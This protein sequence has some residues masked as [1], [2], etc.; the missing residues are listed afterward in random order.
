MP[1][2]LILIAIAFAAVSGFPGL[3]FK[4][5]SGTGQVIAFVLMGIGS[6]TGLAG[7]G[8]GLFSIASASFAFP[9]PAVENTIIGL[10]PLSAFFL[11]PVFLTGGLGSLYGLGYWKQK[12]HPH[13]AQRLQFF[14]GFLVSGIGLLIIGRHALSFLLGWEIMALS[15]F[16]LVSTEDENK[17][18]RKSA[19]VY[20][21]STH[22]STLVLFGFFALWKWTTGSFSL[23]PIAEGAVHPVLLNI[24][25]FLALFGFGLKAGMMPLHFWLPGAHASAP[26]HVSAMLS[27][28]MLKIGIYGLVRI[29]LLLPAPPVIWGGSIL[30]FGLVSG[31]FGVIFALSQHDVKRLL[32]YH[33][34]ENIGIILMGL[35]L[36][37]L[38]R[39]F[40]K[41][42]WV[43][44]G[45]AGCLL[46]VWNHSLFKTLLFYG[47]GSVI[48]QTG[49][50][51]IDML[52]GL[53]KSM[54]WTA[55]FFLIG[56]IA[57]S[58]IPPLN[59]FISEFI[60]FIGLIR[61]VTI[62]GRQTIGLAFSA[63]I[64]AMI[65]ALASACFI[66]VY[67]A[68][69]LGSPRTHA[70]L[71]VHE[72]PAAMIIPMAILALICTTI[73]TV[74]G[75]VVPI[76]ESVTGQMV[77]SQLIPLQTI[78]WIAGGFFAGVLFIALG[79]LIKNRKRKRS[80]TWDCGYAEPTSRMQ[81][82]A[83]SFGHSLTSMFGWVL[84]PQE[85]KPKLKEIY[86]APASLES[87]VD[88]VVLD[89]ALAP[90]F[91]KVKKIFAWFNKFQR[92]QTQNYLLYIL[93]TVLLFLFALIPF[94]EWILP[95]LKH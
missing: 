42:E 44:L 3:F 33:S 32:A 55:L 84:R 90:V 47:A 50:R 7:A 64:L 1:L 15:A 69:F 66:K 36:A 76:L 60:I 79:V 22:V 8:L 2:T 12:D 38:G 39:S 18:T 86:P 31:L 67:T 34:V 41:P 73:G 59:G 62:D 87:H 71:Y 70:S 93:I 80:V 72:A 43:A 35:G 94:E 48:R 68:V 92:G 49:R 82:T 5:T 28:V 74:P 81:Y 10:D 78:S 95:L 45:M 58:G 88:E 37:F 56:A 53:S 25:F 11:V 91:H 46:H 30:F 26:S 65:G 14:W 29:F 21:I 63:P 52:G 77:L 4:K 20:L 6:L 17:E 57:I 16:I 61:P 9:W 23:L 54:P 85:R 24:L 89:R 75:L 27:G 13:N 19:L 83:S 51:N 40:Q